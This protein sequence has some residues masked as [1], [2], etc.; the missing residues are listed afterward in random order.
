[1]AVNA[2]TCEDVQEVQAATFQLAAQKPCWVLCLEA[3]LAEAAAAAVV[4]AGGQALYGGSLEDL[5]KV[6][7]SV[8]LGPPRALRV[9]TASEIFEE[10]LS[11]EA[12]EVDVSTMLHKA[13]P[14]EPFKVTVDPSMG[15]QGARSALRLILAS[16]TSL[17]VNHQQHFHKLCTSQLCSRQPPAADQVEVRAGLWALNFR[18]VLVAVGAIPMEVAGHSL[19]LGG[20]CYGRLA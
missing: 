10:V 14:E 5:R 16:V 7:A 18:D 6:A 19:G 9:H 15:V 11:E 8:E 13:T 2:Q 4:E 20:E 1:M 12:L 3:P 17:I